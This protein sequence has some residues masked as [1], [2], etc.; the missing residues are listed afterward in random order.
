[1][2]LK[3]VLKTIAIT[4]SVFAFI[5]VLK[6]CKKID[7]SAEDKSEA[8]IRADVLKAIK[9]EY[10]NVS[11][12]QIFTVNKQPDQLFYQTT[13]GG[14]IK[15]LYNTN[16]QGEPV[17]GNTCP[18]TC[19]NTTDPTKFR[20]IS[21]LQSVQR[22][23]QCESNG[24][25]SDLIIKWIVSLPLGFSPGFSSQGVKINAQ[26]SAPTILGSDGFETFKNIGQDPA[27]AS[28][29]RYEVRVRVPNVAVSYFGSGMQLSSDLKISTSCNVLPTIITGFVNAPAAALNTYLPCG[30]VDKVYINPNTGPSN[31][32]TAAGNTTV[33]CPFPTL[34]N[35]PI[36]LQQVEY[37]KVT[38]T[39]G[40]L[41]WV[42]QNGPTFAGWL[43]GTSTR[44]FTLNPST[45]ILN[46]TNMIPTVQLPPPAPPITIKWLVRY[47]NI[48]TGSC[49]QIITP[50]NPASG[51]DPGTNAPWGANEL[52]FTEVFS[53]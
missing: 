48:K 45:G 6:S 39:N 1:M 20:V 13:T 11:G 8:A 28:S 30:R 27:C 15:L 12:G 16:P 41:E 3:N 37:R 33:G 21:T 42:D 29:R 25:K 40:S 18:N 2:K 24:T 50:S 7:A 47:R 22:L 43:P 4:M 14:E 34:I 46:L 19:Q 53:L 35:D 31:C 9:A 38:A 5:F 52:W 49:N 17:A 26:G 36:D 10:G 51:G 32:A 23:Y 44:S